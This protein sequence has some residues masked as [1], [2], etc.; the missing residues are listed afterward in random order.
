[1]KCNTLSHI[2][3]VSNTVLSFSLRIRRRGT[4][5]QCTGSRLCPSCLAPSASLFLTCVRGET[6]FVSLLFNDYIP[7]HLAV[8]IVSH[9]M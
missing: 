6:R 1:M 9:S 3:A 2:S 5:S 4:V 7:I 8:N